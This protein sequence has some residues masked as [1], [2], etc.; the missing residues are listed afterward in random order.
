MST[1]HPLKQLLI[2]SISIVIVLSACSVERDGQ[3]TIKNIA[4]PD[5][6][7][8]SV[9]DLL[10]AHHEVEYQETSSGIFVTSI[11]SIPNTKS[12]YWL[13]F[14]NDT[15]GTVASDMYM[16]R[17]GEKVEWRFVSGY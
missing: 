3:D 16:L 6:S 17:G 11:D 14:V 5:T 8:V 1:L 10:D 7:G 2:C 4:L 13:Y 15:A 12:S 9:F